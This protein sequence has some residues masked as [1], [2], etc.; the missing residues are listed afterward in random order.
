[1]NSLLLA[2]GITLIAGL[3]TSIGGLF[4]L[5]CKEAN[6]KILSFALGFSVGVMVFVSIGDLLPVSIE[7]IGSLYT[8]LTFF[9]GVTIAYVIDR[10]VPTRINPHDFQGCVDEDDR[11]QVVQ[12]KHLFRTAIFTMIIIAIHNFPEGIATFFAAS[13]DLTIGIGVAIAVAIHN[14]PEGITVA[15]PIYYST[16]NRWKAFWYATLSG[17]S[18][19]LGALVALALFSFIR[20]ENVVAYSLSFAS[21]FMIFIAFDELYPSARK[22]N[23]SHIALLGLFLGMAIIS[24]SML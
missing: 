20:D 18:E 4:V 16:G 23:N 8:Y 12:K 24:L 19:P 6:K 1:M 7:I 10:A 3:S 2:L 17:L 5:L 14:I 22:Y 9:F 15:V 21:G 11:R 13:Y